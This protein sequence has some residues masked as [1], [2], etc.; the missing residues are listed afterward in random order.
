MRVTNWGRLGL[1]LVPQIVLGITAFEL[2]FVAK[3]RALNFDLVRVVPCG[4]DNFGHSHDY[5]SVNLVPAKNA[6]IR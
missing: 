4:L 3:N 1:A 5:I 6:D 2:A